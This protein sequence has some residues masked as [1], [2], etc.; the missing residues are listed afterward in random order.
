FSFVLSDMHPH[1]LALPFATLAIGLC[2]NL[3]MRKRRLYPWEIVLYTI[4]IGGM[5]F[6]NSWDAIY[7]VLLLGA[8]ALRRLISNGTGRF[9]REDLRGLGGFVVWLVALTLILYSPFFISFRSQVQGVVPNIVWPTQF[10][11]F[12]IMFGPFIVVLG[13]YL[14]VEA[15]RAG[16]SLNTD[17]AV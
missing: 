8:E 17:F 12:F 7:M 10:Q 15:W 11:Q 4:F 16:P 6:L 9:T 14:A 2:A 3:V 5:V 13:V 1:V